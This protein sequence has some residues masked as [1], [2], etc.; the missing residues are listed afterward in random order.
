MLSDMH[1]LEHQTCGTCGYDW[2]ACGCVPY[3]DSPPPPRQSIA[4]GELVAC[5]LPNLMEGRL[6]D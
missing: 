4:P 3:Q 2:P 1:A 6:K 5:Y